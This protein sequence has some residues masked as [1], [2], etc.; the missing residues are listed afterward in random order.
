MATKEDEAAAA[1]Y[2]NIMEEVKLRALSINILTNASISLHP[3][4]ISEY[5]FLQLRMLCEL[6]AIGCLVA[7]GD[8]EATQTKDFQKTWKADEM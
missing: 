3:V 5:C 8:I 7:H 6:I 2:A 1:L 4:L